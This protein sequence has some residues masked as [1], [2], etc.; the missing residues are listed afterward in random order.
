MATR[1][2]SKLVW[3][4][5]SYVVLIILAVVCIF[6][7]LWTFLTSVKVETDIVTGYFFEAG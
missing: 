1:S 2:R 4:I 7:V 3:D 6:P 5:A